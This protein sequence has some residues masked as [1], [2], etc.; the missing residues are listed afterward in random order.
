MLFSQHTLTNYRKDCYGS[1]KLIEYTLF[2]KHNLQRN[3][4][5]LRLTFVLDDLHRREYSKRTEILISWALQYVTF[6]FIIKIWTM[7]LEPLQLGLKFHNYDGY[8][9]GR[10]VSWIMTKTISL[11][12]ESNESHE[13]HFTWRSIR[14]YGIV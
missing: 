2:L 8:I 10:F 14:M 13:N 6:V 4:R 1:Q 3:G 5:I 12:L 11:F 7:F 9:S